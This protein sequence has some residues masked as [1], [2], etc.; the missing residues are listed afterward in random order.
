M[1][2][3]NAPEAEIV[4]FASYEAVTAEGET[5]QSYGPMPKSAI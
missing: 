3:Y 4:M 5:S 1:K 2:L